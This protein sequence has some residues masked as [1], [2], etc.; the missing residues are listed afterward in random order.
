M[1]WI[2]FLIYKANVND[3]GGR[4]RDRQ[5]T[6]WFDG[7]KFYFGNRGTLQQPSSRLNDE[8]GYLVNEFNTPL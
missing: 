8:V 2:E 6:G 1:D 3:A 4:G 7:V 5:Q